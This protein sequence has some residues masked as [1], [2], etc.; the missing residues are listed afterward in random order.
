MMAGLERPALLYARLYR[1][2]EFDAG[3]AAGRDQAGFEFWVGWM[4]DEPSDWRAVERELFEVDWGGR[5]K[6]L[7]LGGWGPPG[8]MEELESGAWS[9]RP[10][11]PFGREALRGLYRAVECSL[12]LE[13]APKEWAEEWSERERG[14]RAWMFLESGLRQ[15]DEILARHSPSGARRIHPRRLGGGEGP[16][17]GAEREAKERGALAEARVISQAIERRR[18]E[19]VADPSAGSAEERR[20]ESERSSGGRL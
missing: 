7:G 8:S 1:A 18:A 20:G 12:E 17:T 5:A 3:E 4:M 16:M 10:E 11:R 6:P 13:R 9:Q 14:A 19:R 2:P 15:I